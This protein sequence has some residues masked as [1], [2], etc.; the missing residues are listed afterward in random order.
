[1]GPMES[2]HAPCAR[3]CVRRRAFRQRERLHWF[4]V[5][6]ESRSETQALKKFPIQQYC[7]A[8]RQRTAARS[9]EWHVPPI[10]TRTHDAHTFNALWNE[11]SLERQQLHETSLQACDKLLA[12]LEATRDIL[13]LAPY[14]HI[15]KAVGLS[16]ALWTPLN[17]P[18]Y[19]VYYIFS[20]K[21]GRGYV[22][23]VGL[24]GT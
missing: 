20:T 1:M 11:L 7:G 3:T 5:Y 9:S 12:N 19:L 6:P 23:M 2:R 14:Q 17:Q 22:G 15:Q 24:H 8:L 10:T 13:P 21:Y 16:C 18:G 4:Y